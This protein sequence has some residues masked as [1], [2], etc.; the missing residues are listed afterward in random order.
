MLYSPY[1]HPDRVEGVRSTAA[2]KRP[3]LSLASLIGQ[4]ILSTAER[5]ARLGQIYEWVAER[6][7]EY[8]TLNQGGWQNSIRH[9]L[10]INKA[11]VRMTKEDGDNAG[12]G[13]FWTIHPDHL[14]DFQDGV[15]IGKVTPRREENW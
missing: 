12:K 8:Y 15:F 1:T 3:K 13:A 14:N 4:A 11:F 9:N 2:G 5:K 7:P 6:Y 10:T